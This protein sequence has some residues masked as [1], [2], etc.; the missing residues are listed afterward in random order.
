VR[1]GLFAVGL[2]FAVVGA[3][4]GVTGFILPQ[5][6][7][8]STLAKVSSISAPN[9]V[10]SQV[11]TGVVLLVNTSSG[12]FSITWSATHA[13]SVDLYQGVSCSAPSHYCDSGPPL[14]TWPMNT[15]GLWTQSGTLRS[16]L[17]LSLTNSGST[18]VT[19]SGSTLES[20]A[21]GGSNLPAWVELTILAG[22]VLL[23]AIGGLA[24]FLGLFLRS[25]VYSRPDAVLPRYASGLD[26]PDDEFDDPYEDEADP[27]LDGP[28][29]PASH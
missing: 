14:V 24:V 8:G 7:P 16:P 13:M 23:V 17:L 25:G 4:L 29:P 6:T 12:T 28:E 11:R 26:G 2:A 19:F 9:I 5:S 20:Y 27:D 18:N 21:V 10:P 1:T 22:A 15:S 3:V